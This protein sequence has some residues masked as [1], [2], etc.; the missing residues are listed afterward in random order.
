MWCRPRSP[1]EPMYMPGR[2]RTA[3]RPSRTVMELPEYELSVL[4]RATTWG[5][6]LAQPAHLDPDDDGR[7]RAQNG[8]EPVAGGFC[9]RVYSGHRQECRRPRPQGASAPLSTRPPPPV[10]P[11]GPTRRP[12][13][14]WPGRRFHVEQAVAEGCL[15]PREGA[16]SGGQDPRLVL[17]Q[18]GAVPHRADR[19]QMTRGGPELVAVVAGQQQPAQRR[20]GD[21]PPQL[22][23]V[24]LGEQHPAGVELRVAAGQLEESAR[25]V[26]PQPGRR[27]PHPGQR[28]QHRGGGDRVLDLA[29][30]P[31]LEPD[32][33]RHQLDRPGPAPHH[34]GRVVVLADA[35]HRRRVDQLLQDG[36]LGPG[37]VGEGP[38]LPGGPLLGGG[39]VAGAPLDHPLVVRDVPP[40]PEPPAAGPGGGPGGGWW[41]LVLLLRRAALGRRQRPAGWFP[42]AGA[43]LPDAEVGGLAPAGALIGALVAAVTGAVPVGAHACILIRTCLAAPGRAP[44]ADP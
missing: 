10:P 17:D 27:Q 41:S 37:S 25:S 39:P 34:A 5:L 12:R 3:S 2:L 8:A 38:A 35:P 42:A 20:V 29:D 16:E 18:R 32:V 21:Q 22:R 9:P 31:A 14:P 19:G 40:R 1:V 44:S 24:L 26:L 6:P 43:V 11:A 4:G 15:D 23:G 7:Q 28:D 36:V 13:W 33:E 30:P